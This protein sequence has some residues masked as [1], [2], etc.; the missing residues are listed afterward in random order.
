MT[1]HDQLEQL[2]I[3][4]A[5]DIEIARN[6]E[7]SNP[8][9][10]LAIK[11]AIVGFS[12]NSPTRDWAKG[13]YEFVRKRLE[14]SYSSEQL[15]DYKENG[16]NVRLF[17]ALAIGFLLGMYQQERISDDQFKEG[18]PQIAGLIMLHL[19]RLTEQPV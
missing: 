16:E 19:P 3:D 18:E 15:D 9:D 13:H 2:T 7:S 4:F 5:R 8:E 10:D 14:A 11:A 1:F 6:V 12:Y 17:F